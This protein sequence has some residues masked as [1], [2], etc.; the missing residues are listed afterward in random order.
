MDA[1]DVGLRQQFGPGG[2]LETIELDGASGNRG[3]G[4]EGIETE[5]ACLLGAGPPDGTET[6]HP[7]GLIAELM[8]RCGLHD[9]QGGAPGQ[10]VQARQVAGDA[11]RQGDGVIGYRLGAVVGHVDHHD[12][13]FGGRI[14]IDGVHADAIA[15]DH[16]QFGQQIVH[17][18]RV[19]PGVLD[20]EPVG[21]LDP[22]I[23]CRVDAP[24]DEPEFDTRSLGD[25]AFDV[26]GLVV[27][28][29]DGYP[30]LCF[31]RWTLVSSG[32]LRGRA[33]GGPASVILAHPPA[34]RCAARIDPRLGYRGIAARTA[35]RP[36]RAS[37]TNRGVPS[38][39]LR[40]LLSHRP[41]TVARSGNHRRPARAT[42]PARRRP[43]GPRSAGYCAVTWG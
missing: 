18:R 9:I 7:E 36:F 38:D 6:K 15:S 32:R 24:G 39:G 19:H 31:L 12:A 2:H 37:G 11:E 4:D 30:H 1:D 25:F 20:D 10:A 23:G 8:D 16:L 40:R 34:P 28:I 14:E 5:S 29:G 21:A 41:G 22:G 35:L 43:T 33:A 17:R 3:V 27:Q 26:M 13:P 42:H